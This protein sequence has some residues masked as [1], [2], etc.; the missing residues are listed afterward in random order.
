MNKKRITPIRRPSNFSLSPSKPMDTVLRIEK[1][2]LT[3]TL[4][5]EGGKEATVSLSGGVDA[6]AVPSP[7]NPTGGDDVLAVRP[8]APLR[9]V[10]EA[11]IGMVLSRSGSK[12]RASEILGISP[13]TLS[14]RL[15]AFEA[16]QAKTG[17]SS[18]PK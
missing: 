4:V 13:H 15:R 7:R 11:Y 18:S 10:E 6:S 1:L 14:N 3:L 9:E 2:S 12:K 5:S 17:A 16:R 8:G